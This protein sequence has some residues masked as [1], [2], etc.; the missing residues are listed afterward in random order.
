MRPPALVATHPEPNTAYR[1]KNGY[2]QHHR[3]SDDNRN[4]LA[5]DREL[6]GPTRNLQ[7]HQ[8]KAQGSAKGDERDG[9]YGQET[10]ERE[11][12]AAKSES[13]EPR[14]AR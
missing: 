11:P 4:L 13:P 2:R 14:P 12:S 5:V 10:L 9:E 6:L 1:A 3:D 7:G 8:P